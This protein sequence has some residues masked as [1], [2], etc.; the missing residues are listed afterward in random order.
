MNTRH[1]A[2][3]AL[4]M[5]A[6]LVAQ[7]ASAQEAWQLAE[8]SDGIRVY[9]RFVADSPLREF[10]GEIQLKTTPDNVVR[11]LRDAGAFQ[12]WMPDV[13]TSELLKVT[14]TEQFHYLVNKAPFPMS[15]RDGIYHFTY[16]H[17]SDGTVLVKVEAV[18]DFL[19]VREGKVRIPQA[20]GQWKLVPSAEGVSVTYQ[21]H[22]APG[23]SIPSWLANQA[24][25][26]TP[27]GTLKALR[28]YLQDI[29]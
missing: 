5:A 21:M 1:F 24:V 27:Y 25:V 8:N 3:T 2:I 26:N 11:V 6:V 18:P 29:R 4:G 13:V 7:T 10:K 28:S 19:P 12:K 20:N 16:A 17:G 9:T 14:G 15:N 22:A 23:G